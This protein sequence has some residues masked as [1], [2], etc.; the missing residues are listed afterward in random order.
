MVTPQALL[1]I[2]MDSRVRM[3]SLGKW[4]RQ[5]VRLAAMLVLTS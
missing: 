3:G 5:P 2:L 4:E 1:H